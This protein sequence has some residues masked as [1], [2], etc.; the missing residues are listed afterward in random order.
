M[1]GERGNRWIGGATIKVCGWNQILA[2]RG[3]I[4]FKTLMTGSSPSHAVGLYV[5]LTVAFNYV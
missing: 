2:L 3:K 5:S 1:G 4:D